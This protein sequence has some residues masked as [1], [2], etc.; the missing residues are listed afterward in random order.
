MT[1]TLTFIGP[2]EKRMI[3]NAI[4]AWSTET[5]I[6]FDEKHTD[7]IIS[8]PHLIFMASRKDG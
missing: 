5:C 7:A 4:N 1:L 6:R 2:D 8:E 3:R